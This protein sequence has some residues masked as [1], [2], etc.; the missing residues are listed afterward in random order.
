MT[1]LRLPDHIR[2]CEIGSQRIFLDLRSDRYFSLPPGA[3]AAFA[4]LAGQDACELTSELH[5]LLKAGILTSDPDGRQIAPTDHPRATSSLVE[6]NAGT[7][8]ASLLTIIQVT[9]LVLRARRGV[10]RRQLPALL[11]T[12][13]AGEY[14]AASLDVE[15]LHREVLAFMRARRF[16][17]IAPSCLYDSLALHVFLKRRGLG[18]DLVIGAKLRPFAAHCWLQEQATVLNDRLD[19]ARGFTPILVA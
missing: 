18:A 4:A 7:S 2:F 9:M 14:A 11:A 3:D 15:R 6:D 8:G 13:K 5:A 19:A 16:V 10:R 17:P 12:Q 1:G